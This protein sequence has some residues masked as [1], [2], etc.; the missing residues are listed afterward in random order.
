M[1]TETTF[2]EQLSP[3]ATWHHLH[4][5]GPDGDGGYLVNPTTCPGIKQ[6]ATRQVSTRAHT[7]G[8]DLDA[9]KRGMKGSFLRMHRF[10]SFSRG[11]SGLSFTK[12]FLAC[13]E[14]DTHTT[15]ACLGL[16]RTQADAGSRP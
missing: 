7:L 9:R 15:L 3:L 10:D 1:E 13:W 16:I 5:V 12:S 8:F 14:D 6:P 4:P 2:I 11:A